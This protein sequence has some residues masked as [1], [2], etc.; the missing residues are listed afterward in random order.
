M[1]CGPPPWVEVLSMRRRGRVEPLTVE[2]V[3]RELAI[4]GGWIPR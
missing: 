1:G 2:E 3:V 4:L